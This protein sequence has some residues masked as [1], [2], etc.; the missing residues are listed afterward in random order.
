[1]SKFEVDKV[2]IYHTHVGLMYVSIGVQP[3]CKIQ[4]EGRGNRGG[5][6][7]Q[8]GGKSNAQTEETIERFCGQGYV[9]KTWEPYYNCHCGR[10]VEAFNWSGHKNAVPRFHKVLEKHR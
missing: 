7:D 6:S 5:I 3:S 2:N 8:V 10:L 4:S 9:K 1:M